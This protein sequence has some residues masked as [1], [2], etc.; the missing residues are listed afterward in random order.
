MDGTVSGGDLT[1]IG[2]A[3]N[4]GAVALNTGNLNVTATG[5]V[6]QTAATVLSVGGKSTFNAAGQTVTLNN[7][8]D[9]LTGLVT[10]TAGA[11]QINDSA[12]LTAHLTTTGA[13]ALTAIGKTLNIDG[14]V[15]GADLTTS[16]AATNFGATTLTNNLN[17]TATGAVT[18][19]AA[20]VLSVGGATNI[21]AAGQSVTL[22]NANVLTGPVTV[23]AG[24]TTISD[25][26]N[27][28]AHL[29]TTGT[30][31]LTATGQT[32]N[33]DGT[34]TGG[35]LTTNGAATNLGAIALNSGNL[36]VTATGPVTQTAAT[37]LSV[38]GTTHITAG[39]NTV[40]LGNS[41]NDFVGDLTV[42][43]GTTT[44]KDANSLTAHLATMGDTALTAVTTL[45]VDGTVTGGNLTTNA[46]AT[47]FGGAT[48]TLNTGNLTVNSAGTVTQSGALTVGGSSTIN[49][50]GFDV[51]LNLA[52]ND[53]QGAVNATGHDLKFGDSNDL[54]VG[55]MS[56][57]NVTLEAGGSILNGAP[58]AIPNITALAVTTLIADNGTI[59][60]FNQ[61]LAVTSKSTSVSAGGVDGNNTSVHIDGQFGPVTFNS[62]LKGAALIDDPSIAP[63][64]AAQVA[65]YNPRTTEIDPSDA[66]KTPDQI[67]AET[68]YSVAEY[69]D[70]RSKLHVK[71]TG[72]RLPQ[73]QL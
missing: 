17:V 10:A 12:N 64:T 36:S 6:T 3:T 52:G 44:I 60:T 37:L 22:A 39:N 63:V 28:T 4:L 16:G 49:A 32:I 58:A 54:A 1:T 5:A 20:T 2:A 24:A 29:T 11:T 41:S 35:D 73:Q 8:G 48:T 34:V 21:G 31:A 65:I 26:A 14:T 66:S 57:N 43:G 13:T 55:Q 62:N 56:G 27:L 71:G 51:A 67:N 38:G 42:A 47:K 45:T 19:T 61:G 7:A 53:F 18:Q 15:T 70:S 50:A 46:S 40:N 9:I 25:T 69:A 72:I 33:V 68:A 59:G 23:T 30:T